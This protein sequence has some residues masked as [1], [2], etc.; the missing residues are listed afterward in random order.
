[1]SYVTVE[2]DVTPCCNYYDSREIKLG[3]VFEES[4]ED[5]WNGEAYQA[6]RRTLAQGEL[7]DICRSSGSCPIVL[8]FD[9]DRGIEDG[10]A[11]TARSSKVSGWPG[12]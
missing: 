4:I 3:N 7:P 1:M 11:D 2:G 9:R 8:R 5:I 6:L 12:R 10:V